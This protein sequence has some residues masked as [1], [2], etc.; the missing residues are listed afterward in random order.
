M[1]EIIVAKAN[2]TFN[3]IY[4][5]ISRKKSLEPRI[6]WLTEPIFISTKMY[7]HRLEKLYWW[8]WC[9]IG[10]D[11]IGLKSEIHIINTMSEKGKFEDHWY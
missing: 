4:L 3:Y 9:I 6:L 5:P 7:Y 8:Q 2:L 10:R 11:I 1:F